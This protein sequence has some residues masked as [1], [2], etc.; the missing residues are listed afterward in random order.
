MPSATS[1]ATPPPALDYDRRRVVDVDIFDLD[2]KRAPY[3]TFSRWSTQ[4]PFY[5]DYEGWPQLM[6]SRH[7]DVQRV[8]TDIDAF[9][10]QKRPWGATEK[11]Y[12]FRGLPVVTDNDPPDH[13]RLRRLMAPAFSPRRLAAIEEALIGHVETELDRFEA[14]G[15]FDAAIDYGRALAAHVLFSLLLQLPEEDWPIFL[16]IAHAMSGYNNLS[17]GQSPAEA[18]LDAWEAGRIYCERMIEGRRRAPGEDVI[19]QIIA[20]H[21][22]EGRITTDELLATLFVLYVAG[23]GGVANTIG[24]TLYRLCRHRDQLERLQREPELLLSAV[25]EGIRIDPSGYHIIRFATRDMDFEGVRVWENMPILIV[26]GAPNYDPSRHPDPLRFDI[27]REARRDTMAFGYGVH[28]CIGMS[29]SRMVGRIAVGAAVR[30]FPDL[31]LADRDHVP[32]IVGGPKERGPDSVP[33][34]VR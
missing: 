31:R 20:A 7:V 10:S 2:F 12:Y 30:R 26:T 5:V 3:E 6:V 1:L 8:L 25:D 17:A 18:F 11:Y 34:L 23:H 16:R 19:D 28:H 22:Q 29:L 14:A 24:W 32:G 15:R 27:G 33:V 9:T 13:T 4:H 21:T